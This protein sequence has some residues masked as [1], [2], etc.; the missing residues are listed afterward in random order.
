V[1]QR[2]QVFR[3]E[4]NAS[5]ATHAHLFAAVSQQVLH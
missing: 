1:L 3:A 4:G 2:V 5:T